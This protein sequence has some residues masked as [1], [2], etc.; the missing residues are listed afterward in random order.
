[1]LFTAVLDRNPRPDTD[2]LPLTV[3][4]RESYSAAGKIGGA[5]YR[6]REAKPSDNLILYARL[7]DR[8]LR[9]LFPEG[10]I[11]GIVLSVT[12]VSIDH[13]LD[14]GVMSIVGASLASLMA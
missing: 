9:P 5:A 14:L 13:T 12:P 1:M 10:M 4:Y 2:F 11:N 7:T 6:R 8:A 3:D